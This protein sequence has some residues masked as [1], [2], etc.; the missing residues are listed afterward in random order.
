MFCVAGTHKASLDSAQA[1]QSCRLCLG[2]GWGGLRRIPEPPGSCFLIWKVGIIRA[3]ASELQLP[4]PAEVTMG[5]GQAAAGALPVR[6]SPGESGA[7]SSSWAGRSEVAA[8]EGRMVSSPPW[9]A[10]ARLRSKQFAPPNRTPSWHEVR[11]MLSPPH[12]S[13]A[14]SVPAE[15]GRSCSQGFPALFCLASPGWH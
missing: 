2:H 7:C 6:Y 4:Q 13:R 14:P 3:A 10:P 15:S 8:V 5:T 1:P 12:L 11:F 9:D